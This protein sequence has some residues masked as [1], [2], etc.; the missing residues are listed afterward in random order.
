M[1]RQLWWAVQVDTYDRH[2]DFSASE[3]GVMERDVILDFVPRPSQGRSIDKDFGQ[4]I[5][6]NF[7]P[8]I[9]GETR[10]GMKS[11]QEK[12]RNEFQRVGAIICL[13]ARFARE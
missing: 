12:K 7:S 11:E 2:W 6:L 8:N 9:S 3:E 10:S 5:C 13:A 4:V 1:L